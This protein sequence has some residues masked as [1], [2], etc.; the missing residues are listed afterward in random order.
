MMLTQLEG[1][2]NPGQWE[3]L[4]AAFEEALQQIPSAIHQSYLIQ[5]GSERDIWRI[6][7]FWKS[8]EALEDYRMSVETPEGVIMFQA[9]GAE[10]TLSISEVID[11]SR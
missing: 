10:P 3:R 8:R 4:K 2:V 9:A 11:Y 5:D 7:T 6:V 1:K